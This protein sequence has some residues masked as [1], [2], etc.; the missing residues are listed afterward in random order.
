[1]SGESAPL[2]PRQ[3]NEADVNW[4]EGFVGRNSSIPSLFSCFYPVRGITLWP[5]IF[6]AEGCDGDSIINHERI[7]IAQANETAIVGMY[8]VWLFDFARY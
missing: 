5:F 7:H 2:N 1:M 3:D 4:Y 6:L 8:V